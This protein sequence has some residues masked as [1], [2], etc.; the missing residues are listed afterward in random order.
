MTGLLR[1]IVNNYN[2][3]CHTTI[4]STPAE[5]WAGDHI[6]SVRKNIRANVDKMLVTKV[7]TKGVSMLVPKTS[8][9][10]RVSIVRLV[11]S[12]RELDLKGFCKHT[13]HNY[14]DDIYK[15]ETIEPRKV[16]CNEFV[17]SEAFVWSGHLWSRLKETAGWSL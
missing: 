5:V 11:G 10:L 6:G 17:I 7:N 9:Y 12:D 3:T 8:D 14:S 15:V 4:K 2:T 16:S 13:G 1:K